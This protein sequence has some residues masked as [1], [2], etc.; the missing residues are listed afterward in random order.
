M[1]LPHFAQHR[2]IS[3]EVCLEEYLSNLNMVTKQPRYDPNL[4]MVWKV[5]DTSARYTESEITQTQE[6]SRIERY[7]LLFH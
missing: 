5:S 2:E 7:P 3:R 4:R 6:D 1:P